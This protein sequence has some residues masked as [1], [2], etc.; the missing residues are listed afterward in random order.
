MK[1]ERV[2]ELMLNTERVMVVIVRKLL[3]MGGVLETRGSGYL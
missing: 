3:G 1:G 2:L